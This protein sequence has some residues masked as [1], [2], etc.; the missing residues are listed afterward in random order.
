MNDIGKGTDV[1]VLTDGGGGGDVG[2]LVHTFLVELH[3]V[4]G[5]QQG[6]EGEIGVGNA[7]QGGLQRVLGDEIFTDDDCRGFGV[8]NVVGVF[9]V[10]KER[11]ASGLPFFYFA[12]FPDF[13][14]VVSFYGA[15]QNCGYLL[16]VEFH[17]DG[18]WGCFDLF[19]SRKKYTI[20][21][22]VQ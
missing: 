3:L 18:L 2:E 21:Y 12:E 20:I 22:I 17:Q 11:E 1:A 9:G 13:D 7:Q 14:I 19:I 16:D 15:V 10:G 4:V 6:G 8:V 5:L